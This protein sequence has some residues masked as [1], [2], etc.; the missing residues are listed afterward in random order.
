M[1]K[2]WGFLTFGQK[3]F[4]QFSVWGPSL[5]LKKDSEILPNSYHVCEVVCLDLDIVFKIIHE[6]GIELAGYQL[7]LFPFNF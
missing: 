7:I 4:A 2:G 6:S 1:N 3:Q 5:L